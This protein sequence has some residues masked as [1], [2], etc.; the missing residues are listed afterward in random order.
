[1]PSPPV[2]YVTTGS[3][4]EN[5]TFATAGF[6]VGE[7]DGDARALVGAVGEAGVEGEA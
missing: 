3:R 2:V 6:D 4:H 5:A 7:A 1:M